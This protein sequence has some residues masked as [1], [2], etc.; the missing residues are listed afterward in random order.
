MQDARAAETESPLQWNETRNHD[1]RNYG[2]S[3]KISRTTVCMSGMTRNTTQSYCSSRT[4][5]QRSCAQTD[6]QYWQY[7]KVRIRTTKCTFFLVF[8][9]FFLFFILQTQTFELILS[10]PELAESLKDCF[11]FFSFFLMYTSKCHFLVRRFSPRSEQAQSKVDA[12]VHTCVSDVV[13]LRLCSSSRTYIQ[14]LISVLLCERALP[15]L[16]QSYNNKDEKK[17]KKKHRQVLT[18]FRTGPG[19]FYFQFKPFRISEVL[20]YL[21]RRSSTARDPVQT[22]TESETTPLPNPP[23]HSEVLSLTFF[24]SWSVEYFVSGSWFLNG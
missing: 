1:R 23:T 14:P 4:N 24:K 18:T 22:E 8:F 6:T 20:R 16:E 17:K 7:R 19:L 2:C 3:W 5:R 13:P 15:E 11:F 9:F 10:T 12:F 21:L